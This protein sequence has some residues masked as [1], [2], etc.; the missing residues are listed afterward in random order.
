MLLSMKDLKDLSSEQLEAECGI[1]NSIHR[2]RIMQ[3]VKGMN[4]SRNCAD[5]EEAPNSK[6]LDVFISYRRSN[7]SHLASLLK[8]YLQQ[9]GFSVF[10]DVERME[11]GRFDNN[12]LNSVR[13]ARHFILVLTAN[14]LDRCINDTDCKDWVHR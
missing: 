12:L 6:N 8:V 11:A 14:A 10:I 13:Q 5:F 3:M 1:E 2:M 7:G 4:C 9:K